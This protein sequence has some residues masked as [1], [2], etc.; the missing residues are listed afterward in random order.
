VTDER[1][2]IADILASAI[3][4]RGFAYRRNPYREE[5]KVSASTN[6]TLTVD[7]KKAAK[8]LRAQR[9][10]C[11]PGTNAIISRSEAKAWHDLVATAATGLDV[12]TDQLPTFCDLAG[13]A[14]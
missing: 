11:L 13:V 9:P 4:N 7:Q 2:A 12:T 5:S 1:A 14:D 10:M 6:P 3:C 8:E